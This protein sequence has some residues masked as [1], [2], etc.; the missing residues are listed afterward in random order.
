MPSQLHPWLARV[1]VLLR[2]AYVDRQAD[3]E[4]RNQQDAAEDREA[5]VAQQ[6]R[7]HGEVQDD[8]S[9]DDCGRNFPVIADDEVVPELS[10]GLQELH[11]T[12]S[13]AGWL[14]PCCVVDS[15][16]RSTAMNT[17]LSISHAASSPRMATS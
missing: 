4:G 13:F 17:R 2:G 16:V 1:R 3:G 5:G 6:M 14:T 15:G 12:S 7:G 9:R 10:E 8:Q 11:G